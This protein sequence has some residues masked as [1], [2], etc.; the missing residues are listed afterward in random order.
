MGWG[1]VAAAT[2]AASTYLSY[3]SAKEQEEAIDIKSEGDYEQ[4]EYLKMAAKAEGV[5][6]LESAIAL[7]EKTA[8]DG[9]SITRREAE[10]A[11]AVKF[12]EDQHVKSTGLLKKQG[13]I[14]LLQRRRTTE[15]SIGTAR[16]RAAGAGVYAG[17]GATAEVAKDAA[18]T[19]ALEKARINLQLKQAQQQL[20][21]GIGQ[22]RLNAFV[23]NE[24]I[25]AD[26]TVLAFNYNVAARQKE[27]ATEVHDIERAARIASLESGARASQ[28]GSP[29]PGLS[30]FDTA[31]SG[32]SNLRN[33]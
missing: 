33:T 19:G 16:A 3:K 14:A 21:D 32:L 20:D 15:K 1:W 28:A 18:F 12:N 25:A 11:A 29:S 30:A 8:L 6:D 7:T 13:D 4:I 27:L 9:E 5:A 23:A 10:I 22:S 17:G 24:N 31:L 26:R 2:L